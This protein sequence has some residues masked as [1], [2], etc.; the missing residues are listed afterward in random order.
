MALQVIMDEIMH[1]LAQVRVDSIEILKIKCWLPSVKVIGQLSIKP[2]IQCAATFAFLW[3][4]MAP[5]SLFLFVIN[6]KLAAVIRLPYQWQHSTS[7]L[8]LTHTLHPVY[9]KCNELSFHVMIL[10]LKNMVFGQVMLNLQT[11][12]PLFESS[13]YLFILD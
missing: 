12:H 4:I 10:V 5:T 9:Y 13:R 11:Y 8:Q 2:S 7:L 3:S 1:H 6:V